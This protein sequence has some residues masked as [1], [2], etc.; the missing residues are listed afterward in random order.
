MK[1]KEKIE[2]EIEESAKEY[3]KPKPKDIQKEFEKETVLVSPN[4][5]VEPTDKNKS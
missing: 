3:F 5:L 1:N 2:K 4:N